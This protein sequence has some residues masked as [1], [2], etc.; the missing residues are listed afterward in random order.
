[1]EYPTISTDKLIPY[2]NNSR[3]H[4]DEQVSQIAASIREFGFLNPIIVDKDDGIIAGHGRLMAAKKLG[5]SEVPLEYLHNKSKSFIRNGCKDVLCGDCGTEFTARKDTKPEVCKRCA[6]ARGGKGVR[7][8]VRAERIG[9]KLCKKP[10]R[11]S[12]G[13]AYC[14]I[15]CRARDKKTIR[16]CKKCSKEF[17]AYKTAVF[18]KTN[19]TSGNFCSRVCYNDYLC[20]TERVSGYG[21]GWKK[22]REESLKRA[23]FCAICGTFKNIDVHH[24]MPYRITH[25]NSQSNLIALCKKHHKLVETQ[26]NDLLNHGCPEIKLIHGSILREYQSATRQKL[27]DIYHAIA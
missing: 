11:K 3:T 25:D 15:D 7:G 27:K 5:L 21:S 12:T 13:Q 16:Q 1:M 8:N 17:K 19:N 24:I 10:I 14:S 20:D 18:G 4:S 9:C 23:R 22:I 26:V 2:A 6:S